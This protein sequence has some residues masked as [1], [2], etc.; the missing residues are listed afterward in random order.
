MSRPAFAY[1]AETVPC[2]Y[3]DVCRSGSPRH[4]ASRIHDPGFSLRQPDSAPPGHFAPEASQ[5][6]HYLPE[7]TLL[8][9]EIKRRRAAG[10]IPGS[11]I[12][13]L[14]SGAANPTR[15]AFLKRSIWDRSCRGKGSAICTSTLRER[16]PEPAF[17]LKELFGISYSF[18][19]HAVDIFCATDFAI[20][21]GDLVR[22]ATVVIAEADFSVQFLREQFPAWADKIYRVYNG[23]TVPE[24]C[25]TTTSNR[26]PLASSASDDALRRRGF[27]S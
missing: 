21:L 7:A 4:A 15:V 16:P 8:G 6:V 25:A 23:I 20:S 17:L 22:E 1:L 5:D 12:R 9:T 11:S 3:P 18:T 2:F 19:G 13:G 10:E 14:R 26:I 24:N 27:P